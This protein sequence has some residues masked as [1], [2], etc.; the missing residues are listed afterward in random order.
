MLAIR[1]VMRPVNHTALG[2]PFVL[3]KKLDDVTYLD[4]SDSW[5][6]VYVV[7]NQDGLLLVD[8][9][10]EALMAAAFLIVR[11]DSRHDAGAAYLVVLTPLLERPAKVGFLDTRIRRGS[12]NDPDFVEYEVQSDERSEDGD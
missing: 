11:Q 12:L 8:L 3:A 9:E 6:Q 7:C 2:I 1:V 10:D 4:R 5:R